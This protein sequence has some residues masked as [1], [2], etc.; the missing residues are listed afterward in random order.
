V[1][2]RSQF[3]KVPEI[4]EEFGPARVGAI[5]DAA[6][7]EEAFPKSVVPGLV[8]H[9]GERVV[10]SF[11][12]AF[13]DDGTGHNARLETA[14]DR[15]AWR[16]AFAS[17]RLV[18]PLARFVEGRAWFS[19]SA[20][21][22]L[23]VAGLFRLGGLASGGP[24]RRAT[25]LTRPA[26]DVVAP[27]HERMPVILPADLVGPWLAGEPVPIGRLLGEA[28]VLVAE[29]LSRPGPEQPTLL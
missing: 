28:P 5:V 12:W 13:F 9:K 17:A 8:L 2:G 14:A 1:C 15:P 21:R 19:E 6:V 7:A 18:L 11:S 27:F 4:I 10:S 16:D 25:M 3:R 24:P 29:P 23:A 22:T 26:E 20:G